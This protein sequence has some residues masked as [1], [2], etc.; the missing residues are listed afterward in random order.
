MRRWAWLAAVA[1]LGCAVV[2][3]VMGWTS[4]PPAPEDASCVSALGLLLL[5]ED[6]GLYV[7]GVSDGGAAGS[8]GIQP[9]DYLTRAGG[10]A[11][12]SA[13]RLEELIAQPGGWVPITLERQG[14]A[15]TVLL[16][17]R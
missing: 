11:L 2:A 10:T 6:A 12:D 16:Q 5:E 9:G 17:C 8:A 3:V 14:E 15:L 7:L 4:H 13:A 1:L